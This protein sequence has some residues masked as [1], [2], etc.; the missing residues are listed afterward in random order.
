MLSVLWPL[1]AVRADQPFQRLLPFLIDLDGWQGKK[2]EGA[3]MQM[4]DTSMTTATRDYERGSAQLHAAVIVGQGAPGA[5]PPMQGGMNIQTSEGHVIST[6]MHGMGVIK[7][8]NIP[9][10]SGSLL[11]SLSKDAL[12]SITFEGITEEEALALAEKF[13]W[14]AIQVSAQKK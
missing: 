2:P 8:Y 4:S 10:K 7:N 12:F 11:V 6:T 5:L 9:E 3:S 1:S 13:D 14:K